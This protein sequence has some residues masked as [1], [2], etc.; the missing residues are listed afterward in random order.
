MGRADT[1][2]VTDI[3]Y[4]SGTGNSLFVAKQMAKKI[5]APLLR[6]IVAS[7][8]NATVKDIAVQKCADRAMAGN[9]LR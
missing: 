9:P 8:P 1:K 3:F 6:P 7:H 2:P 5:P 4:F